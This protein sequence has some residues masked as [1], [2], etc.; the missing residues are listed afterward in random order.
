MYKKPICDPK[1]PERHPGCHGS[2]N[3]FKDWKCEYYRDKTK[4]FKA[5]RKQR[6]IDGVLSKNK[7]KEW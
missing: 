3:R 7:E 5:K 4:Q 2:C 1:C 6:D